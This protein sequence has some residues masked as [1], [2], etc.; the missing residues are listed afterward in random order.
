MPPVEAPVEAAPTHVAKTPLNERPFGKTF[1]NAIKITPDKEKAAV[2]AEAVAAPG[3]ATPVEVAAEPKSI[4]DSFT[5]ASGLKEEAAPTPE[6][7][8]KEE[9]IANL[10]KSREELKAKYADLEKQHKETQSKIPT[11]YETIRTENAK[12][13]ADLEL[14]TG[15]LKKYSLASTPEFKAKYEVPLKNALNTIERAILTSV[16][17]VEINS[18]E[19]IAAV[20]LPE[21]K[22][23]T[24]RLAEFVSNVDEMSKQKI[25]AAISN[26]DQVREEREFELKNP[27]PALRLNQERQETM[28][29]QQTESYHK[30]IEDTI[31]RA[32]TELPWLK[33]GEDPEWN[34][35]VKEIKSEARA[36]WTQPLPPDKHSEVAVRAAAF[37]K[38]Y[39]LLVEAQK[40][41]AKLNAEL[42][43]FRGSTPLNQANKPAPNLEPKKG[44]GAFTEKFNA[45]IK[46]K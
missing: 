46:P 36:I 12:I 35:L 3:E 2:S 19:F 4:L 22:E 43:K 38:T 26:Y 34:K 6:L 44:R 1:Q 9:N 39:N 21:S 45:T 25:A 16:S 41:N 29:K 7:S 23:R 10:R 13:K 24:R 15:E 17:D 5:K 31:V 37:P 32:E 33:E 30:I 40:E 14:A 11:D 8:D 18:A 42:K 28:R 27:D 20:N